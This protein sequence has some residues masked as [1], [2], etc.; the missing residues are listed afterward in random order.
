MA[1]TTQ[2]AARV[3]VKLQADF[4]IKIDFQKGS[5]SPSR[6]F[7]AMTGLI[8]TFEQLDHALTRSI[9]VRVKPVMLLEDIEAGS[10]RAW[11]RSVVQELPDDALAKAEW[12][13]IIGTYLV[14]AKRAILDWTGGKTTVTNRQEIIE[15]QTSLVALAEQTE[16]NQI[17][18]YAPADMRE[19]LTQVQSVSDSLGLLRAGDSATFE[20]QQGNVD[21]NL[22]FR[23]APETLEEILT[24]RIIKNKAELLLKVKKPD[25]LGDSRWELRH[26]TRNVPV[27]IEDVEWLANFQARLVNVRPGDALRASVRIEVSYGHDGELVGE[28]Y[29]VEK[30]IEVLEP[31]VGQ[32]LELLP[33]RDDR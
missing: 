27:K 13:P 25:Y 12:K 15:L 4:A 23:I 20:S 10:I 3:P 7:R 9:D 19:I 29:F 8:E 18:A 30:V 16:I 33:N 32:S 22:A 6:V 24:A 28:H 17:P 11:L 14:K 1:T 26:G 5:E 2:D 21:F 31:S